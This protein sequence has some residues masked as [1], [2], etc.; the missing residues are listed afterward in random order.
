MNDSRDKH[1]PSS[2]DDETPGSQSEIEAG[3]EGFGG[4]EPTDEERATEQ[5]DEEEED[6]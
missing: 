2:L 4:R 6:G 3:S 5:T 1:T